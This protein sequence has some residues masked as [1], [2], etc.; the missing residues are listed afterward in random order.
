MCSTKLQIKSIGS[1]LCVSSLVSTDPEGIPSM[2]QKLSSCK[3]RTVSEADL[4]V[5]AA[6]V[7]IL[8]DEFLIYE[9]KVR[10]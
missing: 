6:T 8:I 5:E 1:L 10:L 4:D 3:P 9:L 7:V 2:Q